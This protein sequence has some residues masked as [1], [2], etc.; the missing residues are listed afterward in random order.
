MFSEV[1]IKRVGK[2]SLN[3]HILATIIT[4]WAPGNGEK[5]MY[6]PIENDLERVS[7]DAPDW[8]PLFKK[9]FI[10]FYAHVGPCFLSYFSIS[11]PWFCNY[12]ISSGG[13]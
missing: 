12:S 13:R 8:T 7:G 1:L 5:A 4:V 9:S 10:F 11:F 2:L 3:S 6:S